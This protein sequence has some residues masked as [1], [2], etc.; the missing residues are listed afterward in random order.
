MRNGIFLNY[1][2]DVSNRVRGLNCRLC[3]SHYPYFVY[4]SNKGSDAYA[5]LHRLTRPYVAQHKVII[6]CFTI[7]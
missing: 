2:A 3:L 6:K 7:I 5:L 4:A 1:H